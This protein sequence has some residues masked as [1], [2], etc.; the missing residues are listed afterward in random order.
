MSQNKLSFALLSVGAAMMVAALILMLIATG[1][2]FGGD[3][4]NSS[5][6]TIV[7][8]GDPIRTPT[9]GP[10]PT[11]TGQ[12]PPG[13]NAPIARLVVER[14]KID[15]PVDIMGVDSGGVMQ[16]PANATNVAWYNFSAHPGFS[17]NAVFAGH[18]DY[19]RVG[20]AVFWNLK[21]LEPGDL[22]QVRLQD[23]TVYTYAVNFKQQFDA[24]TAPVEQ[25][26]GP[27]PGETVTLITCGGTFNSATHQYDKRLVVRAE[28]VPETPAEATPGAATPAAPSSLPPG[29]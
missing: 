7:A 3:D 17:G 22:I 15:A 1:V 14:A 11:P 6:K 29:T 9:P 4:G 18:V 5:L 2:I 28:R 16:S 8:F 10:T 23:G 26:V 24:A 19:I 13:S 25:I 27:T 21:D 12:F 20:P